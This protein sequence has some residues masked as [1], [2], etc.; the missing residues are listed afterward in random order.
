[1]VMLRTTSWRWVKDWHVVRPIFFLLNYDSGDFF[2]FEDDAYSKVIRFNNSFVVIILLEGGPKKAFSSDVDL[3][4]HRCYTKSAGWRCHENSER[5]C[6]LC[7]F[8]DLVRFSVT[9]CNREL[10]FGTYFLFYLR[11]FT[12]LV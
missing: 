5:R 1:M 12:P 6:K 9:F 10:D 4:G 7:N 8:T 11:H 2:E 3:R